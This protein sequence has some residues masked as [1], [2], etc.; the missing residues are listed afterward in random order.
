[1]NHF[2][3]NDIKSYTVV[4]AT[5]GVLVEDPKRIGRRFVSK[6]LTLL[7]TKAIYRFIISYLYLSSP[8]VTCI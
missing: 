7:I 5:S 8:R 1:M 4:D 6:L 3:N 2:I